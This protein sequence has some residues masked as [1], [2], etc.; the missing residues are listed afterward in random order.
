MQAFLV[1]ANGTVMKGRSFGANK[2]SI[3]EVVFNTSMAGYQEII[4]DPS[5]KGQLVTLTYP[6]IGNYGINPDDME[7][8]KIQA[9]GLIV[10]E[11][12]KRPSN[13]QSKETLS[14]FLIRFGV[15]A[16]E[17]IDTRK[18][19]RIIRNSGAMSCGIF[20]S[21]TYE[22]S[23]LE[24]VKNAPS[25]EGQDLAQV[26]TC[27]K[28]YVFGAH[29]PSKFKLAVY[30]YGI[31]RNILKLLDAAGFN[32]HV[33][34]AKTKAEDLLKEGFDAFFLS[35]GPGDPAPLDYAISSAKTIMDAKKPLF[36]ICLGHQ[37]IG[38]A[39]GKKTAKLKFGHR[40]GNHPVRNEETG[41]IE[42]TSQNH[43]FHV[44]GESTSEMPITRINLFDNTVAGLKTKG[45]P[46]MAVQYHPEACPG[47][48]DSAYHFQEFYTMVESSKS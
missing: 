20:I 17:G 37:I 47:P 10:K 43:G 16:I 19:T 9:S 1:L 29:S 33:F 39:L 8:D 21:E 6:M 23:F 36:G 14:E 30:D 15:P 31:K 46:V 34:P 27:E 25:M 4:T 7:S 3:G 38:L 13:F 26:V 35:N 2:N 12:V 32:V 40:G 5:Y 22:D 41:K 24:A 42:I 18:L 48:H 28:P 44:L 11:Y 45:L